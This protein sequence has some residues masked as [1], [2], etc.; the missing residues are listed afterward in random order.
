MK[1]NLIEYN[2]AEIKRSI[3]KRGII[4]SGFVFVA[5]IKDAKNSIQIPMRPIPN[6]REAVLGC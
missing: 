6:S 3:P 2:L 1:P 4:I 5:K